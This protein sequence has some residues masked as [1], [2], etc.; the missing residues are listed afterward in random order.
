MR[1]PNSRLAIGSNRIKALNLFENDLP[2]NTPIILDDGF[3]HRKVKRDIDILC[4]PPD[5]FKDH[6]IPAGTMRETL[7]SIKRSDLLFLIGSKEDNDLMDQSKRKLNESFPDK[8]VFILHQGAEVWQ[9]VKNGEKKSSLPEGKKVVISAI[10]RP[11]RF[12]NML[13]SLGVLYF[14]SNTYPDHHIF[15]ERDIKNLNLQGDEIILTTEKDAIRLSSLNLVNLPNI[16]YLKIIL[17]FSD[18]DSRGN[19]VNL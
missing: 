11:E 10:A 4:L 14:K 2:K 8:K 18:T 1:I 7:N 9:N 3:Q 5:P 19:F 17:E 12:L 6:L 16:W 13:K 15:K